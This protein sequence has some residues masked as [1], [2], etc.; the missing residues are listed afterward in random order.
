MYRTFSSQDSQ[1]SLCWCRFL[2]ILENLRTQTL[3][4]LWNMLVYQGLTYL[5]VFY[6]LIVSLPYYCF[7]LISKSTYT[8]RKTL[9]YLLLTL[10]HMY[11]DY[12]F[13]Y[14]CILRFIFILLCMLLTRRIMGNVNVSFFGDLASHNIIL[15]LCSHGSVVRRFDRQFK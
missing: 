12:D 8:S 15:S 3:L 10:Y 9:I 14:F 11:P 7:W 2:I 6:L 13:R 4:P 5:C 1:V